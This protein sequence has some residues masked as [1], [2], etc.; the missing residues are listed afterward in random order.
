[1]ARLK[2]PQRREQLIEVATRL[3][4]E[5]G[6][7]ATTT[8]AIAEAAGVTEPI[9]YR[10]FSGKQ[11]LFVA[12]VRRM[13]E[14]TLTQWRALIEGTT[15]PAEQI[16]TIAREFPAQMRRLEDAYHVLHG[17]LAISNDRKVLAC[18]REHYIGIHAF[19]VTIIRDGQASGQ[20]RADL[21]PN[22]TAWHF[23]YTGIGYAMTSL[24]LPPF[25]GADIEAL[26][27][28]ILGPLLR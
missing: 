16:R 3:F 28:S 27:E 12:I 14:Q 22:V 7:E 11:E 25:D 20:F 18:L 26:I 21:D 2:A 10:H 6:Y 13:S 1:M 24:N 23:I 17:A 4:A 15:D 8:A 9:L 5:R 19:F